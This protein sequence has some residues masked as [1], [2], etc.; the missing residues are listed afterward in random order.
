M[1]AW[2]HMPE[3][4]GFFGFIDILKGLSVVPKIIMFFGVVA[5]TAGFF[6]GAF[7]LLHNPKISSGV[8]LM[9]ASLGWRDWEQVRWSNP[10]PPYEYH[11]DL[12]KLMK[13]LFYYALSTGM[14]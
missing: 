4:G 1:L 13:G 3:G 6:S 11:W 12:G 10:N 8:G 14:F 7:S 2:L 5:V 9:L